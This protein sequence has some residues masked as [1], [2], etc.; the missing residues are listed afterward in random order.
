MT[1]HIM[2]ALSKKGFFLISALILSGCISTNQVKTVTSQNPAYLD[3]KSENGLTNV[4]KSVLQNRTAK[5]KTF[6]LA[7]K[8]IIGQVLIATLLDQG[9]Q[10][11]YTSSDYKL[12]TG[13]KILNTTERVSASLTFHETSDE[14]VT[15]RANFSLSDSS[16]I[17]DH[18]F[19]QLFFSAVSK[20]IFLKSNGI[21]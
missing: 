13:H 11:D 18:H 2:Q 21:L 6:F 15:V 20:S 16:S 7:E 1:S 4:T 10:I 12:I 3:S 17:S 8:K 5:T 9:F 14:F 19:Y